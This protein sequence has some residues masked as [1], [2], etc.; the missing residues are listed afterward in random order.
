[1]KKN[2][3][4]ITPEV[5]KA[6]ESGQGVVALESTIISHGMPYPENLHCAR[7][8]EDT[9]RAEGAVPAT[10][11]I[12]NGMLKV[13]LSPSEL[14]TLA[15][16]PDVS[17]VS[18]RD[19]PFLL[20]KGQAG[21]TTVSAT[22]II[23][24]MA[25]IKVFATGGIGGVHKGVADTWDISAD[26]EELAQTNLAVVCA[27]AKSILDIDKTLEF[28]ETKGVPVIGFGTDE[29]PAFYSRESGCNVDY[30]FDD[31]HPLAKALKCKWDL[32]LNGGVVVAVPVSADFAMDHH[33]VESIIEKALHDAARL[34]VRGKQLTPFLLA[35]VKE[36]TQG[37]SLKT[38]IALVQNNAQVAARLACALAELA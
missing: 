17:K 12:M 20:A 38:N 6:L 27:G 26:L 25:G 8:V 24:A 11:A 15:S 18:R 37:E 1:M 7:S 14:E 33:R 31:V 13:G 35:A 23:A 22:M 28:L 9:V 2:N 10:I 29:F 34:G 16:T 30:R 21:A 32:K 4:S 5:K 3:L 19:I 36:K